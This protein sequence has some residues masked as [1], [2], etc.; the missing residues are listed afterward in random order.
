ATLIVPVRGSNVRR[1]GYALYDLATRFRGEDGVVL[2][3]VTVIGYTLLFVVLVVG[4]DTSKTKIAQMELR[5]K[6]EVICK[7]IAENPL[8]Q[9]QGVERFQSYWDFAIRHN[10]LR[11]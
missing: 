8:N 3:L 9:R 5:S 10:V 2:P 6:L 7:A 11:Y 1:S 4:V